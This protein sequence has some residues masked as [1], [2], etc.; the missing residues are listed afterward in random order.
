MKK[1][2]LT[3]ALLLVVLGASSLSAEN[4]DW[5]GTYWGDPSGIAIQ[6][7]W[8]GTIFDNGPAGTVPYFEGKWQS[9]I[10]DADYGTLYAVLNTDGG[11][12][13]KTDNGIIYDKFGVQIGNWLGVFDL[14]SS[15]PGVGKGE[16]KTFNDPDAIHHGFWKGKQ[17]LPADEE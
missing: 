1:T 16:W 4:T 9:D 3:L 13:Y 7:T 11:G 8:K 14:V 10:S 6:G 5:K 15:Y 17:L 2:L 12:I